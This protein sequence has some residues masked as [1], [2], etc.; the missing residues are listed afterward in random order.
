MTACL[1]GV[2]TSVLGIPL[3]AHGWLEFPRQRELRHVDL[4]WHYIIH[5]ILTLE[6][7][8]PYIHSF[9]SLISPAV[10]KKYFLA[11]CKLDQTLISINLRQ[12]LLH[13]LAH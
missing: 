2:K 3:S 9:R 5:K 6:H 4:K 10:K 13:F 11:E 1:L 12:I 8:S 7:S